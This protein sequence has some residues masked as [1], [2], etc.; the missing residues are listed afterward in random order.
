MQTLIPTTRAE[1]LRSLIQALRGAWLERHPRARLSSRR[2]PPA[3]TLLADLGAEAPLHLEHLARVFGGSYCLAFPAAPRRRTCGHWHK[4][5]T[6]RRG[7]QGC[8]RRGGRRLNELGQSWHLILAF[9]GAPL[10]HMTAA[11]TWA[12]YD[13]APA[14]QGARRAA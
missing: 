5:R 9:A 1:R 3:R 14:A 7:A 2:L 10:L 12:L 13:E 6:G 11:G 8:P 4:E